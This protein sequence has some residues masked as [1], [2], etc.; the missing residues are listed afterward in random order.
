[1][2][3]LWR[4]VRQKAQK[5]PTRPPVPLSHRPRGPL[6]VIPFKRDVV[7]ARSSTG[8]PFELDLREGCHGRLQRDPWWRVPDHCRAASRDQPR[9]ADDLQV[10][11][12]AE[13]P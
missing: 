9:R 12:S 10:V 8:V 6:S 5:A 2:S 1:M 4:P 13:R 11:S 3:F 7:D